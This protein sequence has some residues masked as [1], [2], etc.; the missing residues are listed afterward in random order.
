MSE[1]DTKY[2]Q[3][4]RDKWRVVLPPGKLKERYRGTFDTLGEAQDARDR[5]LGTQEQPVVEGLTNEEADVLYTAD[6]LW[7]MAEAAQER[8]EGQA[9][10]RRHQRIV[11]P[12]PD[13]PF[14]L[15]YLSDMHFGDPATDSKALKRDAEIIRDTPRLWCGYHGDGI[16]NW[17][18]GKLAAL[19]RDEVLTFDAEVQLLAEWL[20]VLQ[21]KLLWVVCGN[22]DNWTRKL[23]GFDLIRS[24]LSGVRVLYDRDE[25]RFSLVWGQRTIRYKV[26]HKWKYSS[27]FN[28]THPIEVGWQRGGADFDVGLGGH[29]HIGTACRPFWRHGLERQAV[30][31]G[32]YKRIDVPGS[33]G[34]ELGLPM[35]MHRGCG[36][37]VFWSDRMLFC[38][39]LEVAADFLGF[40]GK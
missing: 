2:I 9:A 5:Y 36:A 31:T 3:R 26:R 32:T 19:Q 4:R 23:A 1:P 15:A 40:L 21:G 14:G 28:P 35:P 25:V 17:I 20:R 8:A 34:A 29:T 6:E 13:R 10:K 7:S 11:I 16:N 18:V 30:L 37:H 38:N 39:D 27:V 33:Y 12:Q 24:L 22:H